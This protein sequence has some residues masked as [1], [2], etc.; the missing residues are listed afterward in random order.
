[1]WA[2]VSISV[3]QELLA[4]GCEG[5][6][7]FMGHCK[8]LIWDQCLYVCYLMHEGVRVL[9]GPYGYGAGVKAKLNGAEAKSAGVELGPSL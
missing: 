2:I 1:M 9:Q 3:L 5:L 8:V 7:G 6:S 4:S